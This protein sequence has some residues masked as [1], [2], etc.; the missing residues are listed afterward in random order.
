MTGEGGRLRSN[1]SKKEYVVLPEPI[2][3]ALFSWY[4]GTVALPRTVSLHHVTFLCIILLVIRL[5]PD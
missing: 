2:W 4:G 1:I 3:K 5:S